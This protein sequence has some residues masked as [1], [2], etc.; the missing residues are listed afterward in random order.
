MDERPL[1]D[2]PASV[3]LAHHDAKI[4]RFRPEWH[5]VPILVSAFADK[6][7]TPYHQAPEVKYVRRFPLDSRHLIVTAVR[8]QPW[9]W[10][11]LLGAIVVKKRGK[12]R[13]L[14]KA[15]ARAQKKRRH[16]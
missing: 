8:V 9:D 6:T 5:W 2:H 13:G 4:R 10:E 7:I 12:S 11:R 1:V 15:Q 14:T 3:V 16:E